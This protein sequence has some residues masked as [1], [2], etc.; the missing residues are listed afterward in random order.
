LGS[1][2]SQY[3]ISSASTAYSKSS[4][5]GRI[6]AYVDDFSARSHESDSLPKPNVSSSIQQKQ[7]KTPLNDIELYQKPSSDS[8]R[9]SKERRDEVI[10]VDYPK[11][12]VH[13]RD[14]FDTDTL[15]TL[16]LRIEK[17]KVQLEHVSTNDS[18]S[19]YRLRDLVDNLAHAAEQFQRQGMK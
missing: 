7:Q 8:H 2:P 3:H 15:D 9:H 18:I 5:K 4:S 14:D 6:F 16:L 19:Q 12:N 17:A 13:E 1:R 11:R 10:V